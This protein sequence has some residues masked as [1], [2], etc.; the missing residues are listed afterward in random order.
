MNT[1]IESMEL[2]CPKAKSLGTVT[3]KNY[4]LVFKNHCDVIAT[5]GK[6]MKCVIW[7]ITE[8]CERKLD[9]LEGYPY[10]YDK[11]LV[12]VKFRGKT[13]KAM[14]YFMNPGNVESR[15]SAGYLGMVRDGYSYHNIDQSQITLALERAERAESQET[16]ALNYAY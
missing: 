9:T 16:S 8:D 3:L 5:P 11:K 7:S 13:V 4:S 15:P 10:Y 12:K 1:N 6:N 2:R 14:L